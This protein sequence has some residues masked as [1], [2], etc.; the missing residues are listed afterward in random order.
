MNIYLHPIKRPLQRPVPRYL[1]ARLV[2]RSARAPNLVEI[3]KKKKIVVAN[4]MTVANAPLRQTRPCP[5]RGCSFPH[6]AVL[7]EQLERV[8]ELDLPSGLYLTLCN[9][10]KKLHDVAEEI[11]SSSEEKAICSLCKFHGVTQAI[12]HTLPP[13]ATKSSL[14][15]LAKHFAESAI[16][17]LSTQANLLQFFKGMWL[18]GPLSANACSFY[19]YTTL[20]KHLFLKLKHSEQ[21]CGVCTNE[22]LLMTILNSAHYVDGL[23]EDCGAKTR[24]LWKIVENALKANSMHTLQDIIVQDRL[25]YRDSCQLAIQL[26][27]YTRGWALPFV[28]P[29]LDPSQPQ[30]VKAIRPLATKFWKSKGQCSFLAHEDEKVQEAVFGK[31]PASSTRKCKR[32]REEAEIDDN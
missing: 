11:A 13:S 25:S 31:G 15:V 2:V 4:P 27:L 20:F 10:C 17:E 18:H 16:N 5:T 21:V 8:M 9:I 3:Q 1:S 6:K 23:D 26:M 32:A 14:K 12:V 29:P 19:F 28:L 24:E 7:C 30:W 22:K